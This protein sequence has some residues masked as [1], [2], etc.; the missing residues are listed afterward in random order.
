M[1]RRARGRVVRSFVHDAFFHAF[2]T[3]F[4]F[5]QQ[6]FRTPERSRA[7]DRQG[8]ARLLDELRGAPLS[9][10]NKEET[11]HGVALTPYKLLTFTYTRPVARVKALRASFGEA[12][13][14]GSGANSVYTRL[15][16][17]A[18]CYGNG[19]LLLA[20]DKISAKPNMKK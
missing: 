11:Q 8:S 2:L 18:C 12:A 16:L 14:R 15:W 4:F 1:L 9:F 6:N 20:R 3:F 5:L 10:S 17:Q 13:G 7:A 19:R